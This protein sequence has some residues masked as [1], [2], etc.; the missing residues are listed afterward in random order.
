[1]LIRCV[2]RSNGVCTRS[3]RCGHVLLQVNSV[4]TL[5]YSV[6]SLAASQWPVILSFSSVREQEPATL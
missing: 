4:R 5:S 6:R 3:L 2:A 1:M